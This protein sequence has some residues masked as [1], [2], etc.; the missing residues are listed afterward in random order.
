MLDKETVASVLE[1]ES[2]STI[3]YWL[4]CVET[5]PDIITVP[6]IA[7][8]RCAH[9]PVMFVDIVTRLRDPLPLATRALMSDAAHEHGMLRRLQGYTLAMMVEESR[10]LEVSIFRTLQLNREQMDFKVV[11]MDVMTIADE[12]DSQLSK[13]IASYMFEANIDVDPVE[14]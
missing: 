1:R 14:A 2:Q 6:L 7:Q 11:M 4:S 12:V 3:A 13:A 8:E 5:E 9:L 10:M